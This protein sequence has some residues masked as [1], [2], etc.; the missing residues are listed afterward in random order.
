MSA[1]PSVACTKRA[2]SG[3]ACVLMRSSLMEQLSLDRTSGTAVR[4]TPATPPGHRGGGNGDLSCHAAAIVVS[5]FTMKN[6]FPTPAHQPCHALRSPAPKAPSAS[7]IHRGSIVGVQKIN[8]RSGSIGTNAASTKPRMA[9]LGH[10]VP[11][12]LWA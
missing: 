8:V 4:V 1:V 9:G 11:S 3:V 6:L 2:A 5:G 12:I 7:D 10:G